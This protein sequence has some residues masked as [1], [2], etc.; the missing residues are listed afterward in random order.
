[1]RPPERSFVPSLIATSQKARWTSR[2]IDLI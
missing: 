2:A 1:M